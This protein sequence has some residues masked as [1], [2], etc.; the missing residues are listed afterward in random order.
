LGSSGSVPRTGNIS[1]NVETEP[2]SAEKMGQTVTQTFRAGRRRGG[3]G[4][5]QKR[6]HECRRHRMRVTIGG[7]KKKGPSGAGEWGR[8]P[9]NKKNPKRENCRKRRVESRFKHGVQGTL[10]PRQSQVAKKCKRQPRTGG[11]SPC[12]WKKAGRQNPGGDG[13]EE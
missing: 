9:G 5:P 11:S 6:S 13:E 2:L 4:F 3:R 7:E 12:G 10:L 8:V 1:G